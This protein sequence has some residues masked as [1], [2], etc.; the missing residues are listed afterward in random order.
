M[1]GLGG[2]GEGG[3]DRAET[4]EAA[5][6]DGVTTAGADPGVNELAKVLEAT[7]EVSAWGA[8]E[9]ATAESKRRKAGSIAM[10][11]KDKIQKRWTSSNRDVL[12]IEL[13]RRLEYKLE[14]RDC[15][16]YTT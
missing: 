16:L 10:V 3:A 2:N 12:R 5:V 11:T 15:S 13:T 7:V 9:A 4:Y 1:L 14:D 6:G 8:G